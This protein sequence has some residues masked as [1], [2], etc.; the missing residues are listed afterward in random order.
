MLVAGVDASSVEAAMKRSATATS[1]LA[2]STKFQEAERIIRAPQQAFAYI[3]LAQVYARFDTTLRPVL[4]MGAAFMPGVADAVD[5]NKL[6]GAETIMKHLSPIV[7]SQRY[8]RDGYVVESIGPLPLYQTALASITAGT[9]WT[10]FYKR[11]IFRSPALASP[12]ST[13][14]PAIPVASPSPSPEES[15]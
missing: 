14:A 6:P 12:P 10:E 4:V 2:A 1:G 8:D 3:D 15:K 7:M 13:M 9:A 5:L 11:E